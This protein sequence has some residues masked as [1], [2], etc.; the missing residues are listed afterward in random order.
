MSL[1]LR[2][3][4]PQRVDQTHLSDKNGPGSCLQA[5]VATLFGVPLAN[6]PDLRPNEELPPQKFRLSQWLRLNKWVMRQVWSDRPHH[7]FYIA[8]GLVERSIYIPHAV[9]MHSGTLYHDPH[10]CRKGLVS[11]GCVLLFYPNPHAMDARYAA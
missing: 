1:D 9:V 11:Q 3:G 5:A 2:L 6:V 7:G 4:N 10:P 8:C